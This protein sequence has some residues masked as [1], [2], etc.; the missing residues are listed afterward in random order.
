MS[1]DLH[2]LGVAALGRALGERRVSSVEA[3]SHLLARFAAHEH[4]KS[5]ELVPRRVQPDSLRRGLPEVV[6]G[7]IAFRLRRDGRARDGLDLVEFVHDRD[8]RVAELRQR[9]ATPERFR[10]RTR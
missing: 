7:E 5:D 10:L 2:E 3:T 1:A 4:L 6:G 8:L 9:A